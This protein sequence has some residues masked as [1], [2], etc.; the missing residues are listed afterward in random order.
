[1]KIDIISDIHLDFWIKPSSGTRPK[2]LRK[3]IEEVLVPKGGDVLVIAGD[4]THKNFQTRVLLSMLLEYYKD[5]VFVIGN[6]DIYIEANNPS[7]YNQKDSLDR[8]ISL[9]N[10]V[11]ELGEHIHWLKGGTKEVQGIIFGGTMGWYDFSEFKKSGMSDIEIQK[12]YNSRSSDPHY[13][14]GLTSSNMYGDSRLDGLQ[15]FEQEYQKLL[16]LDDIFIDIMVTHVPPWVSEENKLKAEFIDDLNYEYFDK[17]ELLN[18]RNVWIHGHTHYFE[19]SVHNGCRVVS[20][21]LGYKS[22]NLNSE[23]YQIIY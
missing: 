3:F 2:P 12:M 17:P 15:L 16:E 6:H 8:L 10:I 13:V 14:R 18:G 7:K 4:I 20:S 22:E 23:I 11:D 1:M 19:D 5:I 9:Q 21:P